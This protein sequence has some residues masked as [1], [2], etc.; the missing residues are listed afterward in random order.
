MKNTDV[1]YRIMSLVESGKDVF[2]KES[3]S[4][5]WHS[6]DIFRDS[7]SLEEAEQQIEDNFA[8]NK[9]GVSIDFVIMKV[10]SKNWYPDD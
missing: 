8:N 7:D 6:S 9:D 10:Y 1:K 2:G 3:F 5:L 4:T